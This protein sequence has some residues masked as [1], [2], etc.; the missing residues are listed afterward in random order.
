MTNRIDLQ[1]VTNQACQGRW[2]RAPRWRVSASRHRTV[3]RRIA[4]LALIAIPAIVA[5]AVALRRSGEAP[6]IEPAFE[7]IA[8][9]RAGPVSDF[10][11]RDS[12]GELRTAHD[13]S[14][15]RAIV[16]LFCKPDHP[17]SVQAARATAKLATVF[18]PRG[19]LF[20]AV[21]CERSALGE[22]PRRSPRQ[23]ALNCR[24]SST[25]SRPSRAQAGVRAL[26]EAVV[27]A[28]DG[29]VMYR[30]GVFQAGVA[31]RSARRQM[32]DT[33]WN[34]QFDRLTATTSPR[35]SRPPRPPAA[36]CPR[37]H[38]LKREAPLPSRRSCSRAMSRRFS[39]STAPAVT[40]GA[41]SVRFRL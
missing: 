2:W 34:R 7:S 28:P 32:H 30:G 12:S 21:S 38:P 39:G 41:K 10:A 4:L 35:S 29:Q 31:P 15:H 36:R 27:L 26:P 22:T 40:A 33:T 13:W 9:E 1:A 19:I 6:K 37:F 23:Q 8:H 11:L 18:K 17:E 16:L 24:S 5:I 20:L 14:A 3:R 25:R